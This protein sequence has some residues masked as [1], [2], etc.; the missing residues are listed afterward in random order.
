MA[1]QRIIANAINLTLTLADAD[2]DADA[3]TDT[4]IVGTPTGPPCRHRHTHSHT[5]IYV[6]ISCSHPLTFK[7]RID[8]PD[9]VT[10]D[11]RTNQSVCIRCKRGIELAIVVGHLVDGLYFVEVEG[12]LARD[13]AVHARLQ[14]RRPV[15][16]DHV[17]APAIVLAD[18]CHTRV[19]GLAAVD[20][21]HG[22]LAEEEV[23]KVP[24]VKGANEIWFCKMKNGNGLKRKIC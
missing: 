24:N 16:A 12:E 8:I 18:A 20:V 19:D 7:G 11:C 5:H 13:A 23:D 6:Y 22:M 14:I 9:I 3:G 4:G 1:P 21:L 15:L 10:A 17:L 2:A